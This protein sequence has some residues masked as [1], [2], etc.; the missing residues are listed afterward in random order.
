MRHRR[1]VI[2][3]SP[4]WTLPQCIHY[5]LST[6]DRSFSK[7]ELMEMLTDG[8]VHKGKHFSQSVDDALSRLSKNGSPVVLEKDGNWRLVKSNV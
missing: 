5:C 1:R 6:E 8:G 3:L 7:K 4:V 2:P